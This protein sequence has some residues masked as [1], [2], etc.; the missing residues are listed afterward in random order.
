[1]VVP[2]SPVRRSA[3]IRIGKKLCFV[4]VVLFGGIKV[5]IFREWLVFPAIGDSCWFLMFNS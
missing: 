1:M 5:A 3:G 2:E 4:M